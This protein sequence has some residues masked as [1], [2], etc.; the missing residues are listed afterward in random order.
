MRTITTLRNGNIYQ[1]DI[2]EAI[3]I[4]QAY[5]RV[6]RLPGLLETAQEMQ[7]LATLDQLPLIQKVAIRRFMKDMQALFAEK[8]TV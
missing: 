2:Q 1:M 7:D 3:D 5:Q 4:V 8:E 6:N